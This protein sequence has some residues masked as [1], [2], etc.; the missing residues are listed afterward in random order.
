M[1]IAIQSQIQSPLVRTF[2]SIPTNSMNFIHGIPDNTPPF[3]KRSIVV[4]KSSGDS[5]N[6]NGVQVFKLPQNGHLNAVYLRYRM[7]GHTDT[8]NKT[9]TTDADNPFVFGDGIERIELRTHNNVI[10]TM[11]P[12]QIPFENVST[13]L[14]E[15]AMQRSM[16]DL[17][18]FKA[19]NT[20]G[21]EILDPP[22]WNESAFF[23]VRS[24][25]AAAH[26]AKDYIIKL[27]L[28]STFYL[29]DN[30]QTRMLEDLEIVVKTKMAPQQYEGTTARNLTPLPLDDTHQITLVADYINFHENVEEVIRNENHKPDVPAS[31]YQSDSL[32][33]KAR[34]VSDTTSGDNKTL[35]YSVD[36]NTDAL[37]TDLFIIPKIHIPG[38]VYERANGFSS[39]GFHF[40]LQSNGESI[41]SGF[42]AE[43]DGIA[44]RRHSTVTR[45]YQNEGVLPL[46]WSP[47]GTHIRLGLNNTD[48]FFD[49]GI[50]FASLINPKLI[51]TV[52]DNLL[53]PNTF[54]LDLGAGSATTGD[55]FT[56]ADALDFDVVLKR[57]VLLRIDGNTGKISKSLE[58]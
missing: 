38:N 52:S 48:E 43:F 33:Y 50:S 12:A 24:D 26:R 19:L 9:I 15:S 21:S 22:S 49:G 5:K 20:A 27:P 44:S 1:D 57:R 34:Y 13:E 58:S 3:S 18:G 30:F 42:K 45:Q 55:L 37:V 25:H 51:I 39:A 16:L 29:K 17:V 31:L 6:L 46:R 32:Q 28:S 7:F 35:T 41:I 8:A 4:E 23:G 2:Q 47:C 56:D 54:S 36:L 11:Y 53:S 40:E 14:S 10:Q